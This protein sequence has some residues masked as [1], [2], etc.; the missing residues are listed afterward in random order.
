[1][2]KVLRMAWM[3]VLLSYRIKIAFFF[4]FI[5]PM[6]F[7]F[8]YFGLIARG[9]PHAVEAM[10]GP[11]ISFSVISNAL[12]GLSVQLVTMRERDMLRRYHLAPIRAAEMVGSR[13]LSNYLLFLPIVVLQYGLAVWMFHMPVHGSLLALWLMFTLGYLAL[14]AIGLVVAG[15][16]DT[17]QEATVW[18]QILFFALLFLTGTTFPLV[19]LPH[20]VQRLALFMPPTL[21]ILGSAS[22][23]LGGQG[24]AQNLPELVGLALI[25]VSSLGLGIAL[26]RWEKE[27]KTTRRGRMQAALALIPLL[28]V[29]LWLNY[30][31][32]FQQKSQA[33]L[34]AAARA[35]Q[36]E[37]R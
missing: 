13:L 25:T 27:E 4:T 15:I 23:M 12:F 31:T 18:N 29:G 35:F 3:N 33:S 7:F 22:I 1:M 14:G 2:N 16:V 32:S 34:S 11:L 26:F 21:M 6:M 20:F 19:Q 17:V 28:A 9:K 24:I 8:V 36:A 37:M 30:S 5:F 10:M